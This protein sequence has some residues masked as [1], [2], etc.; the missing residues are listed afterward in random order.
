MNPKL[1]MSWCFLDLVV[2]PQFEP[3]FRRTHDEE[4][5]EFKAIDALPLF[6]ENGN[7]AWTFEGEPITA[8][9]KRWLK[10]YV[11]QERTG[12]KQ[13]TGSGLLSWAAHANFWAVGFG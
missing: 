13:K 9:E 11:K 7:I 10:L 2:G 4:T 3:T 6:D 1:A 5:I 12:Q 8:R